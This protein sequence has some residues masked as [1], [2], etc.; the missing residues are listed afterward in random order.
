MLGFIH[1]IVSI[2]S[3]LTMVKLIFA[4]LSI[5]SL[6]RESLSFLLVETKLAIE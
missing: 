2:S 5:C 1:P 4:R 3:S 6:L